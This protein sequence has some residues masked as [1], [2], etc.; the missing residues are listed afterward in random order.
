[1][2]YYQASKAFK[3]QDLSAKAEEIDKMKAKYNMT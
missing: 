3:Q 1:V 2:L